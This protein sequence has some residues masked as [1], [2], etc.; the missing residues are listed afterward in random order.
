M[1]KSLKVLLY[2]LFGLFILLLLLVTLVWLQRDSIKQYAVKQL[3]EQLSTPVSVSSIDITFIEQFPRVSL[4]LND[5]VIKDPLRTK[6]NLLEA[7]RLFFAFNVYDILTEQYNIKL[8]EADSGHCHLFMDAKGNPNYTIL[9]ETSSESDDIFLSLKHIALSNMN[10]VFENPE[11]KQYYDID[12]RDLIISG[13]F[14]GKKE[15]L[16]ASGELIV[17]KVKAGIQLLKNKDITIDIA[18]NIDESQSLYN[19]KKGNIKLGSLNLECN[20][21]IT[22]RSKSTL[23]DLSFTAQK[24]AITDLLELL[25]G[26][27]SHAIKDYTSEGKIYFNGL[28]K[29]EVSQHKQP[30]INLQFGVENGTLTAKKEGISLQHIN[31][32]GEFT[33]GVRHNLVTSTL[34]I[35]KLSF[36][37]GSGQ[38]EGLLTISNFDN[39]TIQLALKGTSSLTDVI[40]FTQ[41]GW[42]EKADGN[43][44]FDLSINGNLNQLKTQQGFMNAE[45]R[46]QIS[47]NGTNIVFKKGNKTIEQIETDFS[48]NGKDLT[49]NNFKAAINQSDIEIRGTLENIIPYLLSEKQPLTANISYKSNYINL[50]HLTMP[51]PA[52]PE[53][54]A[55]TSN[56][57]LPEFLTVNANIDVSQLVFHTFQAGKINGMINWK[58]KRIETQGIQL[59]TMKGKVMIKG[60]IE[61]SSDGN[62]HVRTSIDCKQTDM[63]ELFKQCNNFGQTAI[64]DKHIRGNLTASVDMIGEWDKKLNCNLDKLYASG[65]IHITNGQLLNYAPLDALSK[66]VSID[67]L[68]NLKFADLKNRIEISKRTIRIPSMDVLNNALNLNL[69]GTHTFDNYMDYHLRIKLSELLSK[70]RKSVTN[71]YNEEETSEGIFLYLSMKGPADNLKF[72][73][74]KKGAR[75]QLKENLKKESEAAK[76]IWK[77]ELGIEKDETIKE[78]KTDSDELE[79]EQE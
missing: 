68:R 5:V 34:T 64:T 13:D 10:I 73:Y 61:N 23:L 20:G 19:L 12:A 32:K 49:I 31:C 55:N 41:S 58:G 70:K 26:N 75:E 47:V 9:K 71:E 29:G 45:T 38:I 56:V 6:R 24:L 17:N 30:E 37:L 48:L 25:P 39:P 59:E 69:S 8:I 7:K 40:R 44:V 74:D 60:T 46:G 11:N 50:E 3:N 53:V 63:F 54:D 28:V 43:I 4:L 16:S 22:Q 72:T 2:S 18:L 79:F 76:S 14:K 78:K 27:M 35:P 62:F 1:K 65:D 77:K 36:Q 66:Y 52:Q 33:N 51:I 15:S 57:A 42:I 67:D 21:N